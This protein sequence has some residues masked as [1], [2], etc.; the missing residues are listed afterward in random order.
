MPDIPSINL[1]FLYTVFLYTR[2]QA[3]VFLACQPT[4]PPQSFPL[5]PT[6]FILELGPHPSSPFAGLYF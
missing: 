5:F 6:H 4:T 1:H 3:S 2:T